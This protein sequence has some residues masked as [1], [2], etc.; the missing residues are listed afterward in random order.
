M[1]YIEEGTGMPIVFI[2]GLAEFK[3]AF[4][5]QTRGLHEHY[6]VISYDVRRGL[7]RVTD[8]TL[9]LLVNDLRTAPICMAHIASTIWLPGRIGFSPASSTRR[10]TK[11]PWSTAVA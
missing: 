1:D 4:A 6:R 2:P 10:R 8:Y 7:K 5:Y 9:D 3:E 11:R